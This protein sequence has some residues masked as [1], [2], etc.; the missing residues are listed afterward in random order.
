MKGGG[1]GLRATHAHS[2]HG[3]EMFTSPHP[4]SSLTVSVILDATC[5]ATRT[6]GIAGPRLSLRH[7]VSPA[8]AAVFPYPPAYFLHFPSRASDIVNCHPQCCRHLLYTS[9]NVSSSL[10]IRKPACSYRHI[11]IIVT[12]ICLIRTME[13]LFAGREMF[14]EPPSWVT[15]GPRGVVPRETSS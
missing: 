11:L 9:C 10:Y 2:A 3:A 7:G 1:A 5:Q 13:S 6:N 14:T 12:L 8:L 4:S 15:E